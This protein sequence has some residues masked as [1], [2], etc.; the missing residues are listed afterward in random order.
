MAEQDQ[1]RKSVTDLSVV[2][3]VCRRAEPISLGRLRLGGFTGVAHLDLCR[4]VKALRVP[5]GYSGASP[6]HVSAAPNAD[7]PELIATANPS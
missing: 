6:Y 5:V 3:D 1:Q 7:E 2:G 4:R